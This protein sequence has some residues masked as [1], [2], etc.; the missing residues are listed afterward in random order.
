[1][2]SVHDDGVLVDVELAFMCWSVHDM[3]CVQCTMMVVAGS[4]VL[5]DDIPSAMPQVHD[6]EE[7]LSNY[8]T[9]VREDDSVQRAF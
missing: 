9:L 4:A 8:H 7:L 3:L 6:G 1:M 5:D 2:C